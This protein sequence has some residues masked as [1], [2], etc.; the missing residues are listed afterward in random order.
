MKTVIVD[1]REHKIVAEVVTSHS[2]T[3]DEA[4]GFAGVEWCEDYDTVTV[5]DL[6]GADEIALEVKDTF[7][8]A[9]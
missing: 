9:V 8:F 2:I 6:A 4:C 5:Q 3:L 7:G 1:T